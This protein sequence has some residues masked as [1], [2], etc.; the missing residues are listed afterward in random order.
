MKNFKSFGPGRGGNGTRVLFD[1]RVSTIVGENNVGKTN[2]LSAIRRA[3]ILESEGNRP[4]QQEYHLSNQNVEFLL[5]LKVSFDPSD[6]KD[7]EVSLGIEYEGPRRKIRLALKV[8]LP[9]C[10]FIVSFPPGERKSVWKL[11]NWYLSGLTLYPRFPDEKVLDYSVVA[12][13]DLL[14]KLRLSSKR[15]SLRTGITAMGYDSST[16]AIQFNLEIS[17]P[18]VDLIRKRTGIFDEVRFKPKG[19]GDT[20]EESFDGSRVADLLF[21]L[22]MGTE[23]ERQR[24]IKIKKTFRHIFPHLD[25]ELVKIGDLPPYVSVVHLRS[26][27]E[28]DI[29]GVGAGIGEVITMLAH[30]VGAKGMIYGVDTPESHLHPHALR[31]LLSFFDDVAKSNQL[32]V[33]THSPLVPSGDRIEN[34]IVIRERKNK[35]TVHQLKPDDLSQD[36]LAKLEVILGPEG[37]ELLFAKKVVIVEGPTELGAL[38]ILARSVSRDPD[39]RGIT[40]VGMG[41]KHFGTLAKVASVFGISSSVVCDWDALM[42]IET[43][44]ELGKKRIPVS[45]V[46]KELDKLGQL[47]P[48]TMKLLAKIV[49]KRRPKGSATACY[50]KKWFAE[51][52]RTVEKNHVFIWDS[53]FDQILK[54]A[55]PRGSSTM[56]RRVT[57]SK[58]IHGRILARAI[59]NEGTVPEPLKARLREILRL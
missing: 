47:K 46:F 25:L 18:L 12:F 43:S 31:T 7:L 9:E 26:D 39:E 16:T 52:S 20:I 37:R 49:P 51:L 5:G 13:D 29:S 36:E 45:P 10:E 32:I 23:V 2:I 15:P 44:I 53:D 59:V 33:A 24:W 34:I 8:L 58:V 30:M 6:F 14:P 17:R 40:F 57:R 21:K 11:G 55:A 56:S 28:I 27:F 19:T 48:K 3:A 22:K 38:P 41:G 1:D 4:K 54:S 42:R 50:A 35:S